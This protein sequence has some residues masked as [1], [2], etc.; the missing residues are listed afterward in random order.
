M[1]SSRV[2]RGEGQLDTIPASGGLGLR[3]ACKPSVTVLTRH[4][5]VICEQKTQKEYTRIGSHR[6]VSSPSS[7]TPENMR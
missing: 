4:Q 6:D 3:L 2:T 1:R 7:G 5:H